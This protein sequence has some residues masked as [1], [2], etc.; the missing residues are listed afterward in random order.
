MAG[1]LRQCVVASRNPVKV[2]AAQRA[3]DRVFPT[4]LFARAEGV[5]APSGVSDQPFSDAETLAGARNRVAS[6]RPS[7]PDALI[8]AVE[9]GV[10]FDE[11]KNLECFAW[12]IADAGGPFPEGRARSASFLLPKEVADLV[13]GGME[14]RECTSQC[15]GRAGTDTG[16]LQAGG[17]RRRRLQ[18]RG[19]QEGQRGGGAADQRHRDADGLLR[20]AVHPVPHPVSLTEPHGLPPGEAR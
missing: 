5:A 17:R 10:R 19:Q 13:A 15:R 14:V 3:I 16:L 8:L 1:P 2:E 9:G 4:G 12:C 20:A 18:P 11:Q 6:L 7:H